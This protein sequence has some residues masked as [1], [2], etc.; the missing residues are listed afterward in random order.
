[1]TEEWNMNFPWNE[2]IPELCFKGY[3]FRCYHFLVEITF[4]SEWKDLQTQLS[5]NKTWHSYICSKKLF[6]FTIISNYIHYPL[7]SDK[8][9]CNK[10]SNDSCV[11]LKPPQNLSYVFSELTTFHVILTISLWYYTTLLAKC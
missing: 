6:L 8:N 1:M 9:Y 3:I 10:G 11:A 2:N 7:L 5:S 4:Q